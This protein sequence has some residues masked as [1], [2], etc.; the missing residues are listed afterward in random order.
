MK[1][2]AQRIVNSR[3]FEPAMIGLIIFNCVLIG[4][5]TSHAFMEHY[6]GLLHLGNDIILAIFIIE[7]FLKLTAVA[8]RFSLYFGNGWNLF[9]FSVVLASLI[10]ATEEFALVGRLVRVLRVLSL[11]YSVRH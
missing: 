9:D 5:E 8:P 11:V 7:A 1:A 2:I 3:W 6:D 4:L 10:P